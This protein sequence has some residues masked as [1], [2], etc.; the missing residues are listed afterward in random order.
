MIKVG[1]WSIASAVLMLFLSSCATTKPQQVDCNANVMDKNG[2]PCWVNKTPP[3][4]VVVQMAKHIKP[5]KTRALL[6]N[7]AVVELAAAN[8]GLDVSQDAVVSKVVS[9]KNDDVSG[10][11]SVTS[12]ATVTSANE[13]IEVRAKVRDLWNDLITQKIYMWVVLEGE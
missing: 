6:F 9:V 12:F 5:E 8:G 4:G 3:E 7:R 2:R 11:S 13:S 10:H 1:R